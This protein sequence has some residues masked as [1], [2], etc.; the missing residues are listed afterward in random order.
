MLVALSTRHLVQLLV[1]QT[2]FRIDTDGWKGISLLG[3]SE[4]ANA[5]VMKFHPLSDI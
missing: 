5:L 2:T 4:E 3:D 1:L